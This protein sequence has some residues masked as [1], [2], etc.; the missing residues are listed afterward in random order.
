[1][2]KADSG[3]AQRVDAARIVPPDSDPALASGE[4]A[5]VSRIPFPT[6]TLF[7]DVRASRPAARVRLSGELGA[8]TVAEL[9]AELV[10][11]IRT[12]HQQL[13]I[14][15]SGLSHVSPIC[16]GVLNRAVS[17]LVALGGEL[18]LTGMGY[19]DARGLRR[20]GLDDAIRLSVAAHP[21]PAPAG[22]TTDPT[23]P[24]PPGK[25]TPDPGPTSEGPAHM[26]DEDNA[27]EAVGQA[28]GRIGAATSDE[29]VESRGAA[30]KAAAD[31]EQAIEK[32][33]DATKH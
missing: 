4:T 10:A 2:T 1:V 32:I 12:R 19:A 13:I 20:A 31:L 33:K 27:N 18:R 23:V 14:D 17:E 30:R 15:L 28:K 21:S 6:G 24:A 11:L 16:V 5:P 8:Q 9:G 7:C 3:T 25:Q 26:S 22:D 29:A